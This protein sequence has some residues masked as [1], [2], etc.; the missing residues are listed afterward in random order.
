MTVLRA[1][2]P[3]Q[4]YHPSPRGSAFASPQ[5]QDWTKRLDFSAG[6]REV[7]AREDLVLPAFS[8]RGIRRDVLAVTVALLLVLFAAIL[9][10][11]MNALRAGDDRIGQLSAGIESLE[12]TNASLQ[13]QLSLAMRH[14]VLTRMNAQSEAAA[15]AEVQEERVIT[16]SAL[17]PEE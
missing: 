8:S 1:K 11:D 12:G 13:Q 16:L 9:F 15:E 5:V 6:R 10:A 3:Y 2:K 4:A 17:L 14:P 7:I